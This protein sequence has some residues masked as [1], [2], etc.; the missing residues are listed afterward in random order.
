MNWEHRV[1][2]KHQQVTMFWIRTM[3]RCKVDV[4]MLNAVKSGLADVSS[5]SSSSDQVFCSHSLFYINYP[6]NQQ[7][8]K[9][10]YHMEWTGE[11]GFFQNSLWVIQESKELS[12]A[13]SV[14]MQ[15][16]KIRGRW[17]LKMTWCF[18]FLEKHRKIHS[19]R[20]SPLMLHGIS[21]QSM[22]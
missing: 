5:I 15:F 10:S 3:Y 8:W 19:F 13:S 21:Q 18:L 2:L 7:G 12:A 11:L 16:D 1:K 22:C 6:Q 17:N 20:Q 9:R 14:K 4:D